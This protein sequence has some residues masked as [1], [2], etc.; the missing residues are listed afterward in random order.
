MRDVVI[1][2]AARTPICSFQGGLSQMSAP[3]LGAVAIRA[4][5]ERAKIFPD[6]VSEVILGEVLTAGVGQAPA[7]QAAIAA[8]LPTSVPCLTINKVC[9]SGLKAVMLARQAIA[10]GD[11]E[12]VVAGGMESMSNAPYL[13]PTARA[14]MRMGNQNAV[15]SMIHDGLWDPY[16]N[17]H[18]GGFG[19]KCADEKSFSR[20]DQDAFSK[21]SYER[22]LAAQEKGLFDDEMTPVEVKNRKGSVTVDKDEEP[23]KFNPEKMAKLRPAFGK[24]GT[25]TAA[26]ASKLDDGAAALV[27]M[28]KELAEEKGLEPLATLV[29]DGTFAQEPEWFTTAPVGAIQRAA[30]KA[31]L[32]PADIDLY[33]INEAFAVVTMVTMRELEIPHEK[34]NIWG[35]AVSL[36]HPI[37]CSGARILVTLL[38][39][40]KQEDKKSGCA[41][42][43]IGGGEAVAVI[44]K[45]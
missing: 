17:S 44:V 13:L 21:T 9:G 29:A 14:G 37:G 38:S 24:D 40:M 18:M 11:A 2:S 31:K 25:V 20:E 36:G 8:G 5:L 28:S 7:R 32:S 26:N 12:I 30:G 3:Q 16:G 33:E 45:R 41:S 23:A 15:D 34:V 1:V 27:L 22:A 4:A 10:L 19:D 6:E 35:G 39:Q 43:C 42:L